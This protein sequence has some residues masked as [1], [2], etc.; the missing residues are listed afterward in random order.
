MM[1]MMMT[2]CTNEQFKYNQLFLRSN[3][4][5]AIALNSIE[6]FE[7]IQ[8]EDVMQ[9]KEKERRRDIERMK[10]ITYDQNIDAFDH[11]Q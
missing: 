11:M 8:L 3:H 1:M 2:R 7:L 6:H 9:T 4:C 10:K 5:I